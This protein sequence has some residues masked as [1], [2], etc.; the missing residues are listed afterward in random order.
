MT[1]TIAAQRDYITAVINPSETRDKVVKSFAFLETKTSS[2]NL[3]RKHG[4]I[5]L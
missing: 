1:P 5:P 4:N 2:D 3:S